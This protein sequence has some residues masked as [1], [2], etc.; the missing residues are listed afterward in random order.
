[1]ENKKASKLLYVLLFLF[2]FV[3]FLYL[4]FPYSILKEAVVAEIAKNTGMNVKIEEFGPD[5]PLGFEAEKVTVTNSDGSSVSLDTIEVS[6]STLSLLIGSLS[7]DIELVSEQGGTFIAEASW[8]LFKMILDNNMIPA[9]IDLE[10][11]KFAIGPLASFGLKTYAKEANDLIKGTLNKI[12]IDGNL[13]G[14]VVAD[15]AVDDPLASTG[16]VDLKLLNSSLDMNDPS[17]DLAK[18]IFK[19]ANV[20]ADLKGGK[21]ILDKQ[22]GFH[23]QELLVDLDGSA[24][25]KNPIPTSLLNI[26]IDVELLGSLK[27]NFA[28]LLGMMGGGSEGSVNY[29][30]SGSFG[31]PNFRSQ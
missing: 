3:F 20:K 18:Q 9:S 14:T 13:Q 28:F 19:K 25:L 5:L 17:L 21:L 10:A 24:Q 30:L 11:E 2:S 4:T 12:K 6:I 29:Q 27:E 22:S 8:S 26:G 1:M 31:R 16:S 15:L 7:V 23:S